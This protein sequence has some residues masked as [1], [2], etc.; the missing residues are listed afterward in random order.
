MKKM[1]WIAALVLVGASVVASAQKADPDAQKLAD[2]YTAAFNKGDAK[3]LAALYTAE[4]TRLGPDGNLIA[5]RAAIEKAY[6]DA[7]AGPSKGS[8]L[9]LQVGASYVVTPDVKVMEGRF[10]TTG[11]AAVKGRYV[12]TIARQGKTWLLASV[13]T[14]PDPP[15]AK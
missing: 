6:V 4:A 13:V 12:N 9:T 7:F 15:P 8:T 11:A 3:A 2:Q 5:G 14:I 10:A 1:S